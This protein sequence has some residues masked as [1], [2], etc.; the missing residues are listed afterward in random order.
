ME[1]ALIQFALKKLIKKG[2][3]YDPKTG[4]KLNLSVS[5]LRFRA[6]EARLSALEAKK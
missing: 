4:K 6:I 2:F 1:F 5:E 3:S